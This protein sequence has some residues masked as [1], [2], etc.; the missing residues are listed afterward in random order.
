MAQYVSRFIPGYSDVTTALRGLTHKDVPW[1]WKSE[2]Q[3]ALNN[4]KVKLASVCTV[5]YFDATKP[6]K[7][8][9]DASPVGIGAI[10]CQ[11]DKVVS[12]ASRALS[13]VDQR[14]SQTER[15]MLAVA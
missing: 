9:V 10:L 7:V 12:Y 14:Y 15:E 6:S 4:L 2:H 13:S 1:E 11:D 8:L 3:H 5:Q